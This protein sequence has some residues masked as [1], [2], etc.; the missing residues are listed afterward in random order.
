MK[1]TKFKKDIEYLFDCDYFSDD[2]DPAGN[3]VHKKYARKL[4]LENNWKEIFESIK[5]YVVEKVKTEDQIINF[6]S[7]YMGYGFTRKVIDYPYQFVAY[8]YKHFDVDKN[9]ENGGERIDDFATSILENSGCIDLVKNPYYD[10][11]K[12]KKLLDEIE[13]IK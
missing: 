5:E 7:H 13:K 1:E 12:D 8:F 4:V 11:A 10:T 2:F 6:V 9:W 3:E